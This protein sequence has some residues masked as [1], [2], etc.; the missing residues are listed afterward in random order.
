MRI[1]PE[2]IDAGVWPRNAYKKINSQKK[3]MVLDDRYWN[4]WLGVMTSSLPRNPFLKCGGSVNPQP[5][6]LLSNHRW[7]L[8]KYMSVPPHLEFPSC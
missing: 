3:A 1:L 6:S 2:D 4:K 8:S 5:A 7:K